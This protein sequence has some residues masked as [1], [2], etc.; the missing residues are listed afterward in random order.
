M[1]A[2]SF[3]ACIKKFSRP[4]AA[5]KSKETD[6][7]KLGAMFTAAKLIRKLLFP[8]PKKA[9]AEQEFASFIKP[10]SELPVTKFPW[11]KAMVSLPIGLGKSQ[12]IRPIPS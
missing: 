9:R 12:I 11:R 1:R 4:L 8:L 10:K 7:N 5:S 3:V 2:A 6:A